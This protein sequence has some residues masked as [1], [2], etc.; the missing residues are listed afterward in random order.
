MLPFIRRTT[1]RKLT[2]FALLVLMLWHAPVP[3]GHSHAGYASQVTGQQMERHLQCFH[4]GVACTECWSTDWHW[5]WVFPASGFIDVGS[6][7]ILAHSRSMIAGQWVGL[8]HPM[9][10]SYL[11]TRTWKP[12]TSPLWTYT[13]R[14]HSFQN[15][16]LLNSRQSLPE[17][18][19]II[20]C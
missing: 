8:I 1:M 14:A 6:E 13:N 11:A 10:L 19:G 12:S 5:H 15:V 2:Q 16:A 7:G 4:G 20:R 18:L 17:L 9:C 3:V